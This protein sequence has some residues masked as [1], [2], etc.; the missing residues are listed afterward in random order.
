MEAVESFL[1]R[2]SIGAAG[3]APPEAVCQSLE[4]LCADPQNTVFVVSGD[5]NANVDKAIGHIPG[6]GLAASNGSC[7]SPPLRDGDLA[8][9]WLALDLGVD[10]ESVKKVTIP[11]MSKFTV[12]TNGSF[13][14]LAH[15]SIGW[16][17]Y[18]CDPEL[19]SLMA[20][21]LVIEL[22]RALAPFDVRFVNLKGIVEVIPRR[23]NKGIIVKKILRDIAARDDN[24]G[25]DFVL[26]M[27]DDVSD[28]KM[29][30]SVFSFLSEMDDDYVN[31]IPSP[32]VTQLSQGTLSASQSFLVERPSVRCRD[33]KAPM[34]AF[35][36]AVGKKPSHASQYVESAV[37]VADLLVKM[38]SGS[39]NASF[40][41]VSEG[42]QHLM[43]FS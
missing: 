28:E 41:R 26:C 29:F 6:L 20:K 5:N 34:H 32:P 38:A 25:V 21:F 42:D 10:W 12:R 11:I 43:Q 30:T 18:S 33:L 2:D 37:D 40:G 8:R 17:Y 24:A 31:V 39:M 36:V 14:K 35:T 16:S 3:D 19:G 7:F 27:G 13:I 9:T 1:K 22:E 4:R 15:S 23:L